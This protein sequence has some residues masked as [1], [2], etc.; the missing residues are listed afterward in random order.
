M[1]LVFLLLLMFVIRVQSRDPP[2]QH[3]APAR[4]PRD[5]RADDVLRGHARSVDR[6]SKFGTSVRKSRVLNLDRAREKI[7][8][9]SRRTNSVTTARKMHPHA[10]R[11][12]IFLAWYAL[13]YRSQAGC[14]QTRGWLYVCIL[15]PAPRGSQLARCK[16]PLKNCL[17]RADATLGFLSSSS[18]PSS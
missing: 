8:V 12:R 5:C 10:V 18:S 13:A 3:H 6:S 11:R 16:S 7:P 9:L 14:W 2:V 15:A 17:S 1:V 4:G